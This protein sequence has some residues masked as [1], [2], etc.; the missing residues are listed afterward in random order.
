MLDGWPYP[1]PPPRGRP[2]GACMGRCFR[3]GASEAQVTQ[4]TRKEPT[5]APSHPC[6]YRQQK[7]FQKT[8][9]REPARRCPYYTRKRLLSHL[10]NVSAYC[11]G[12]SSSTR[13]NVPDSEHLIAMKD[14]Y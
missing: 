12:G 6:L 14:R 3:K 1:S 9:L 5:S 10:R 13:E 2:Q 8:Y 11:C 4:G 7:A